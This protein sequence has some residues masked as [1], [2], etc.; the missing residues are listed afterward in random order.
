M[1]HDRRRGLRALDVGL[2]FTLM[3]Q[4][5]SAVYFAGKLVAAVQDQG[6]RL[7]RIER[8]IDERAIAPPFRK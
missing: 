5:V 4:L 8:M 3:L 2:I 1:E 6:D 7:G